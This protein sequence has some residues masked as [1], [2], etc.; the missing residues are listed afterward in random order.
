MKLVQRS[1]YQAW[2]ERWRGKDVIKV[3]SGV[4]RC[5]KSTLL[6]MFQQTLEASGVPASCIL[7]LNLEDIAN[8]HLLDYRS[9]H[10]YILDVLPPEEQCC[11]FLDEVQYV[12][13]FERALSSLRTHKNIDIYVTGSNAYLMS[14]EISTLLTGRYVELKMLPLSFREFAEGRQRNTSA[15]TPEGVFDEYL[16]I[17]SF[18]YL[19][20]VLDDQKAA[21]EYLQDIYASI[22]LKDVVQRLRVSDVAMLE[23]IAQV[24]ASDIGS[25]VSSNRITNTIRS[26]GR[27]IDQKTVD[28]Y[29]DGLVGSQLFYEAPRWNVKGRHLLARLSKYYIVDPGLRAMLI[30]GSAS[31]LGH[32]LENIVFLEL[33]RRGYEA[34]VGVLE[35]GEIDFVAVGS[36]GIEYYQVAASVL[37]ERV[38]AREIAPL[39]KTGDDYPKTILTLDRL[40]TGR[41]L[42]GIEVVNVLDWLD[43]EFGGPGR[44]ETSADLDFSSTRYS[45]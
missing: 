23:R 19:L 14:S 7:S 13:G 42:E 44:K 20:E 28:K 31:D 45:I 29:L 9:L 36:N 5:G 18:P 27:T 40:G 26:G 30:K 15:S 34:Y 12:S 22:L 16:R 4:R 37:D 25:L 32:V 39:R 3:I 43:G 2:L 21:R 33:H 1:E 41:S 17:G 11:L 35:E 10:S 8:E 24:L 38:M 6:E